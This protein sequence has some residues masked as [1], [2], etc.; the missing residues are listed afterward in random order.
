RVGGWRVWRLP[1]YGGSPRE[2]PIAGQRAQYP[3]VAKAGN[4]LVFA[5]S[6]SV[7]AIWR[8]TLASGSVADDRPLIRST[9]NEYSAMYSPDGRKIADISEESGSDEIWLCDADGGNRV[10]VTNFNGPPMSRL[11]WS[12]DSKTILFDV[13]GD[14]GQ[15]LYAVAAVP[16]AKPKRL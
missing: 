12:P 7:S 10:R 14:L 1:A 8:V 2:L 13:R 6:S 15:D 9:V 5:D 3:A 11:R 4:H 16:G